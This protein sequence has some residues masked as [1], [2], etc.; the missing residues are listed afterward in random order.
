MA[1]S[2]GSASPSSQR[3][4]TIASQMTRTRVPWWT[5]IQRHQPLQLKSRW[6]GT[7]PSAHRSGPPQLLGKLAEARELASASSGFVGLGL[8]PFP[9]GRPGIRNAHCGGSPLLPLVNSLIA[10][11]LSKAG[12]ALNWF[13]VRLAFGATPAGSR[14]ATPG[15][16]MVLAVGPAV[17]AIFEGT[18]PEGASLRA[19][20]FSAPVLFVPTKSHRVLTFGAV[21]VVIIA[22]QDPVR[23]RLVPK[24][25]GRLKSLGWKTGV[26][27]D[28][29][30]EDGGVTQEPSDPWI[31]IPI[32][33]ASGD[34]SDSESGDGDRLVGLRPAPL[35]PPREVHLAQG[36]S[37]SSPRW[38]PRLLGKLAEARTLALASSGS[39]VLGL[40]AFPSG[41]VGIRNVNCG[42]VPLLALVNSFLADVL[43]LA[44]LALNWTSVQLVF[45]FSP[46]WKSG[47]TWPGAA[48]VFAVGPVSAATFGDTDPDG[49]S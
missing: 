7:V 45:T 38:L 20:A 46:D 39:L 35:T 2:L 33:A 25:A 49:G 28:S 36:C 41:R 14:V 21:D 42:G 34:S 5:T 29:G 32:V 43:G 3:L 31:S 12:L 6:D 27:Q 44:G 13:S 26:A 22:Y 17:A 24:L 18:D 37:V 4:A 10:D 30:G 19:D 9:F 11:S 8:A 1:V 15:A 16:A 48:V 40:V 23:T 47:G